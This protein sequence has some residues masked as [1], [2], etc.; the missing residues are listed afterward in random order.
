MQK[1]RQHLCWSC[2]MGQL[3]R[4]PSQQW[5]LAWLWHIHLNSQKNCLWWKHSTPLTRLMVVDYRIGRRQKPSLCLNHELLQLTHKGAEWYSEHRC[6]WT[7]NTSHARDVW[8][9]GGFPE[10]HL[11]RNQVLDTRSLMHIFPA[12]YMIWLWTNHFIL[13]IWQPTWAFFELSLLGCMAV[14]LWS[15]LEFGHLSRLLLEAERSYTNSRSLV[16]G[17][18]HT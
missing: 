6:I 14:W 18:Y 7:W 10:T 15:P 9:A 12:T 16:R 4:P 17:E 5:H 1:D 11:S 3:E 8:I 13:K 2:R